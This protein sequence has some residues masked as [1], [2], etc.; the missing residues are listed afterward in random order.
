LVARSVGVHIDRK[1]TLKELWAAHEIGIDEYRKR[2]LS[3]KS[4][5]VKNN[6]LDLKSLIADRILVECQLCERRCRADRRKGRTGVC[7]VTDEPRIASEFLHM[8]EE[9]ELVPSHTIFF[10]GCTFKC[11]YCQNWDISQ[12]PASGDRL[13]P[14]EVTDIINR[15]C[16]RNV[17]WVGGDPT[18]NL[19]FILEVLRRLDLNI[20]QVWNSNMFLTEEAM[21]LLDGTIDIYLADFKYGNDQCAER[22]SGVKNYLKVVARN[23]LDANRQCEMIIRHLVLPNHF[24]CCSKPVLDWISENLDN[25]K[26]RVNIMDQY[27]PEYLVGKD[28][29][30]YPDIGLRLSPNEWLRAYHYGKNLGLNLV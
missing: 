7:G 24:D 29:K 2:D 25:S 8:G 13:A 4:T 28:P 3:E 14:K 9:P 10:S 26:V 30:G 20:A 19:P 1:A 21:R 15:R 16:G 5:P 23:H 12:D 17:N 11:V 27:R 6:L 22:L 18:S